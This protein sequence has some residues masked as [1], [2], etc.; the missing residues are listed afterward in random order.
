MTR[1]LR[2]ASLAAALGLLAMTL[3]VNGDEGSA[4]KELSVEQIVKRANQAAYYQGKNGRSR[5]KMTITDSAGST[6]ERE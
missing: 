3:A 6:R 5:V 4:K 2:I 1:L